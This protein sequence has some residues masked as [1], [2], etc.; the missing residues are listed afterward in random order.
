MAAWSRVI[1]ETFG[2]APLEA[3][4]EEIL[5]PPDLSLSPE[6][7]VDAMYE[8]RLLALRAYQEESSRKE[9]TRRD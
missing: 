9:R 6:P 2:R 4:E 7:L 5:Q 1:E 3:S 8:Q